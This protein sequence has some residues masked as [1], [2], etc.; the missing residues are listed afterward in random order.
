MGFSRI[1]RRWV[2]RLSQEHT[3]SR[4]LLERFNSFWYHKLLKLLCTCVKNYVVPGILYSVVT[5][6][7]ELSWRIKLQLPIWR[8]HP[9]WYYKQKL[10][11]RRFLQKLLWVHRG[12]YDKMEI[13]D[14][15]FNLNWGDIGSGTVSKL[16][17]L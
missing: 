4:C 12:R 7:L 15:G 14:Y 2:P 17:G 9:A 6:D 16:V 1:S 11:R 3:E 13:L 5:L 10:Y 8:T